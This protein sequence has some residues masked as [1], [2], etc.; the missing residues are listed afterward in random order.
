LKPS[1]KRLVPPKKASPTEVLLRRRAK[2]RQQKHGP[3]RDTSQ[4]LGITEEAS[5]SKNSRAAYLYRVQDFLNSEGL[6]HLNVDPVVLDAKLS[7]HIDRL[8]L[9]GKRPSTG[10]KLLAGVCFLC[11]KYGGKGAAFLPRAARSLRGW[12]VLSPRRTKR[13]LPWELCLL[14]ASR[15]WRKGKKEMAVCWLTM[16]DSYSRPTELIDMIPS[17]VILPAPIRGAGGVSLSFNP[18]H[19]GKPSKTGQFNECVKISRAAVATLLQ[20]H[21][22]RRRGMSR[23]WPFALKEMKEVFD[24]ITVEYHLENLEPVLY[25]GRHSGASLDVLEGRRSL[26]EV[27]KRGRWERDSSVR[28]YEKMG[29][30]QESWAMM[31]SAAQQAAREAVRTAPRIFGV[32]GL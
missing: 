28:R 1:V 32:A 11:P 20:E 25:S 5:V 27:K 19:L 13:P 24:E 31:S 17:Q 3:L 22:K 23:L 7:R 6:T 26:V 2:E 30:V 10:E 9:S 4:A 16:V 29:M 12:K 18:E 15:F 21:A 8:Y 14:Y